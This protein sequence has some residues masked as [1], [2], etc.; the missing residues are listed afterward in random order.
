MSKPTKPPSGGLSTETYGKIDVS[1]IESS[2]QHWLAQLPAALATAIDAAPEGTFLGTFTFTKGGLISS[3][4]SH[5]NATTAGRIPQ[6]LSLNISPQLEES[7]QGG[8]K[9][10]SIDILPLDYTLTNIMKQSPEC[11]MHPFTRHPTNGS[12]QLHGS[13]VRTMTVQME[14]TERYR[15]MCKARMYR[16]TMMGASSSAS[17]SGGGKKDVGE[18]HRFVQSIDT[19][20]SLAKVDVLQASNAVKT[21]TS[22]GP[23]GGMSSGGGGGFGN[24]VAQFGKR[25]REAQQQQQLLSPSSTHSAK[26]RKRTM[27]FTQDTPVRTI[28]FELFSQ[29]PHWTLK[30]LKAECGGMKTDKELRTELNIIGD[31]IRIGQMKG[32]WELKAEFQNNISATKDDSNTG[33]VGKNN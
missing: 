14:R 10:P 21:A 25:L 29:Q 22:G 20:H 24:A 31:Y 30:D 15:D 4:D 7:I 32:M 17:R 13:V 23:G 16:Q 2:T 11:V 5:A 19:I 33:D 6:K 18:T 9:A 3:S 27:A 8:E 1:A 26:S 12:V 28:L